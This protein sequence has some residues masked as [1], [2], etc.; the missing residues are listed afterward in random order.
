MQT[1]SL[2][3]LVMESLENSKANDIIN[4]DVRSLTDVA[5]SMVVCSGTSNRHLQSIADNLI[6]TVKKQGIRPLGVE[7]E[8]SGEWILIDLVDVVV[9]IM[10]PTIREFYSL[11]KLWGTAEQA[12]RANTN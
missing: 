1:K 10:M 12:R 4:L 9:H 2:Q 7:G 3:N 11:E 6:Q 8:N 5:D